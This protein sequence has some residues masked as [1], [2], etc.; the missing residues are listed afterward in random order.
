[1]QKLKRAY[2]I[3]KQLITN[4]ISE[5]GIIL[6]E[7]NSNIEI[8]DVN[9]DNTIYLESN[10]GIDFITHSLEAGITKWLGTNIGVPINMIYNQF[11]IS[12]NSCIAKI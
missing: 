3:K 4:D 2:D 1:M 10:C 6:K 12:C 7:E 5:L 9:S 11:P 8:I